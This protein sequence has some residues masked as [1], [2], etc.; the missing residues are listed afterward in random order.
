[1][2]IRDSRTTHHLKEVSPPRTFLFLIFPFVLRSTLQIKRT[3]TD[4]GHGDMDTGVMDI[5][6]MDT[7]VMDIEGMG[8]GDM[9]I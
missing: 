8:T 1:M 2:C 4:S 5:G 7:G 3:R 9:D 6:G